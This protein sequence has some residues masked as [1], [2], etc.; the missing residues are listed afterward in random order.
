MDGIAVDEQLCPGS[1]A[2]TW[3]SRAVPRSRELSWQ[4]VGLGPCS[5]SHRQGRRECPAGTAAPCAST[6]W[7]TAA[8]TCH[9]NNVFCYLVKQ[10]CGYLPGT[11]VGM[12]QNSGIFSGFG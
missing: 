2:D 10:A 4:A 8:R 9:R 11:C 3:W 7:D 5:R 1:A 12:G 6:V